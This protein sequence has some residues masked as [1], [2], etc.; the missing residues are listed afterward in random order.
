MS[1]SGRKRRGRPGIGNA[2]K[3]AFTWAIRGGATREEAAAAGG[4]ALNSF[5]RAARRD[6]GFRAALDEAH[7]VSAEAERREAAAAAA[8]EAAADGGPGEMRIMPNNRRGLQRRKM[9]H[10]RF[11]EKRQQIFL[12]RFCWSGDTKAAAA[13]AGVCENSVY[14]YR[15]SN[16]AFAAEFQ[17][18]LEQCYARLEAEA[19]RQRLVAQQRLREAIES[20]GPAAP[21]AG[22]AAGGFATGDLA[23]E[24]A[25]G[26]LAA[27]FERVMK[28]L[29]R[30]DR[31]GGGPGPRQA[32][33][34][35]ERA[36]SFD[37]AIVALDKR[38]RALGLRRTGLPPPDSGPAEG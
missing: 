22:E 35:A 29:A 5:Y 1:E 31:R 16:P 34:S 19:V 13:E 3:A 30:W 36:W 32:Q 15:R 11:D 23:A 37:E 10:V 7:A 8:I 38:L 27:E 9:R 2:A 6:P 21:A 12:A 25:R 33:P 17:V 24:F 28:L 14:N 4:Y 20:A 26:D 18:A